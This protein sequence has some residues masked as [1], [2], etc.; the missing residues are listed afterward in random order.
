ML[1]SII[2]PVYNVE[3]Y[4]SRC[5][6]SLLDQGDF[7]DY[8]IILVD[9]GSKDGSQKLCDK[10]A[11]QNGNISVIHKENGG[12]S[13]ARNAG[14]K[15]A[16]GDYVMF[17]DSDDY[18]KSNVLLALVQS[19][20]EK[21]LDVLVFNFSHIYGKYHVENNEAFLSDY[22]DVVTGTQYLIDNLKSGTMHMMA[23]NKIYKKCL[24]IDN[25]IF[26]REGYV[27]EDEE[28]SPR[29]L[30]YAER[31]KQFDL[32]VYGYCI[33]NDSI[34]SD[35][36]K[37]KA[38]LDLVDNC[39]GLFVF[40]SAIVD[41]ELRFQLENNIVTL[42]LSAFYKGRLTDKAKDIIG[43]IDN[44]LVGMKNSKKI[45]LIRINPKLYLFVND[46]TKGLSR[47]KADCISLLHKPIAVKNI[48]YDKL[49][50]KCRMLFVARKQRRELRNHQFSIIA[51]SCN[52]GV[53]TSELGEQFRTPTINLWFEAGDYIKLIKNL[54]HYMS[55]EPVEIDNNF[56][57]YPVGKI[58][59]IVVYFMHYNSFEEAAKKWDKRKKR[60]NYNNLFFMMAEKDGCTPEMVRG[61]DRLPYNNKVIFSYNEYPDCPSAVCV[62]E[63]SSNGE[64]AIMTDYV[65]LTG[66]KYDKF[67][68]YVKWLNEGENT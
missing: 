23:C 48:L 68:D 13:S 4:L 54:E 67:F 12:L 8:E 42:C 19:I 16:N 28:W 22:N 40:S 61:F 53:I 41:K 26:F 20:Y 65:G 60:I 63:C 30:V 17:V 36:N 18:I 39:K 58:D 1:L 11:E 49:R 2:V 56:C 44:K 38:A 15:K 7:V 62:K 46:C 24:I 25:N 14:I 51:S 31:V 66:R 6:E 29:L 33:R 64:A 10:Y 37:R 5:I 52:G 27:H 43:L 45:R 47:A 50:K 32:I 9:D 59:D 34:S 35:E 55:F 21:Q 57:N 3:K